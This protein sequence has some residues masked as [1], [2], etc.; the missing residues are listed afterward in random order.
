MSIAPLPRRR[1]AQAA[2]LGGLT[3]RSLPSSAQPAAPW[4]QQLVVGMSGHPPSLEPVLHNHTATRRV[5]PQILDTLIRTD[6]RP[7]EAQALRPAL[8]ERWERV[9]GRSLRLELRRGVTF[10]DGS[11]FTADDVVF[12]L[13]P[14]HLLGPERAGQVI[15]QATL[16][17]IERVEALDE[18][19]V[20]VTMRGQDALLER[21][22]ASWASQIVSVRAFQA[23]GSWPR[24]AAAP[25]GTGPYRLVSQRMDVNLRLAAHPGYWGGPPPFEAIEYRIIPEAASRAAALRAGDAHLVTDIVPDQFAEI[26]AAR[27][28][29][30]VGGDVENIRLLA[31]DCEDPVL[32]DPRIRRALDLAVDRKA[33]VEALW[34]SRISVPNGFQLA[35]FGTTYVPDFP[36]PAH[37]PA[38]ARRLLAEAGYRGAPITYRLLNNYY[39]AQVATAQVMVEMW[40][41]V[42]LQV[43]LEPTENVGTLYRRPVRSI[44]DSS[45]TADLPDH[46]GQA[47]RLLGPRG[48]LVAQLGLWR[49]A[50][51]EALGGVLERSVDPAERLRAHRRML[52]II[53][54]EDPPGMLLHMS[55]QFYGKRRD[56]PWAPTGS[57]DVDFGPFNPG[58]A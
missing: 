42:G 35:S 15:S 58:V 6:R 40:R 48:L 19:T 1:L 13:G 18:A 31:F 29:A 16:G 41:A 51:Y 25:V 10:H 54:E 12:S 4:R 38:R 36:A 33:I 47:W 55:G 45:C 46:L 26:E 32:R 37:D 17:G 30:V 52:Q 56:L 22:L 7:G 8:A 20:L 39:P 9:D 21:R 34:Q 43:R 24:W 28:L 57:L 11:P 23:A 2:A 49:N 14:D 3:A 27:E 5:V 50:E 53:A 44:F